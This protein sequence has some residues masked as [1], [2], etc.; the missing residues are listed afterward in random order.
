MSV[1]TYSPEKNLT[2]IQER[3]ISFEEVIAA[4]ENAQLLDIINHPNPDKYKNQRMYV[5]FVKEYVY[6]VP[7]ITDINGNIFL[8]TIIPSR[9]AKVRYLKEQIDEKR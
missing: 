3:N 8:K 6:L 2:L 1:Y 4:I 9:K 7:F 5:I